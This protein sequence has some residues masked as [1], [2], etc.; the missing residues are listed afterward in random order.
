MRHNRQPSF[1]DQL[2]LRRHGEDRG[3]DDHQSLDHRLA[4]VRSAD[5]VEPVGK[6]GTTRAKLFGS[7][8]LTD[9]HP[10]AHYR[11]A[12]TPAEF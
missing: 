12:F 6:Y 10:A 5:L 1:D 8:L 4:V 9:R 7:D 2:P 11:G 3:D